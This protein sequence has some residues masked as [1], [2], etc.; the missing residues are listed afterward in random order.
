MNQHFVQYFT[1]LFFIAYM[2]VAFVVPSVRT[3]KQTGVNP[4]TFGKNDNA[5][6]F[7]GKWFKLLL[8]LTPFTIAA[9]WAGPVMYNYLLPIPYLQ[10]QPVEWAG[11]L[12]CLL[13]FI[14]TVV[15]QWQMGTSWRIGI[16]EAH[17]TKLVTGG[18]FA[19]SRNPI[20]LGM[21]LTLAGFFLL[22]PNAITL[23]TMVCGCLLVQIQ[24]RLEEEFLQRQ[25]GKTY[26]NYRQHVR[27]FI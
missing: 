18:L 27:R 22:L 10:Q 21:Q 14:W 23:L 4:I 13:S 15:A 8:G 16:D 19:Y 26:A 6:D 9:K 24:T 1:S 17:Q 20:F 7:I 25:H 3:Y 12:L 11:L 5:H 2:A